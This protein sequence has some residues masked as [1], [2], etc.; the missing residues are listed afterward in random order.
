MQIYFDSKEPALIGRI[1]GRIDSSNSHEFRKIVHQHLDQAPS[2]CRQVVLD[3]S[4][5][6]YLSSA[7]FRE[8]FLIGRHAESKNIRLSFCQIPPVLSEVFTIAQMGSAYPI[9]PNV[10][11]ALTNKSNSASNLRARFFRDNEKNT[12]ICRIGGRID[13]GNY[14]E[15]SALMH[16]ELENAPLHLIFDL[17]ELEYLNSAG[18]RELFL[19]GRHQS[20][21]QGTFAICGLKSPVKELFDLAQFGIAYPIHP[22]EKEALQ[23]IQ[24]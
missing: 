23:S 10:E 20:K 21:I 9:Y 4:Q 13:S 11:A 15:F 7:G 17:S 16:S 22:T 24:N 5:T 14:S 2:N 1:T 19:A 6:E 8:L 12:M 3:F 18:F